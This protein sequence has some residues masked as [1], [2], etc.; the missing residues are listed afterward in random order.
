ML[1]VASDEN[2]DGSLL[3]GLVRRLPDLN[4]VRIVDV[5]LKG[6]SDPDLLAW[7]AAEERVLL[8][9]D[10][11][12]MPPYAYGRVQQGLVMP[13]VFVVD[14]RASLGGVIEELIGLIEVTDA[15]ICAN[16]VI[17]VNSSTD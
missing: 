5:G 3:K 4:L 12:T 9:H 10:R 8:T 11:R 2:F 1:R 17:F 7:C 15:T 14:L 13:G 6:I 16:R